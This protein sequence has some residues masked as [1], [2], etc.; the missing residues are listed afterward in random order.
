MTAGTIHVVERSRVRPIE[1]SSMDAA[2][3]VTQ[4]GLGLKEFRGA[5]TPPKIS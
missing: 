2:N 5:V 3:C 1:G 4:W